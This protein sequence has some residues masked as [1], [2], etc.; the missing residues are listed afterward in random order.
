MN[1]HENPELF[2]ESLSGLASDSGILPLFIE[3]DYWLTRTLK[4]LSNYTYA[5]LFVFK[6]GTSLSKA[7]R[8]IERFSEDVDLAILADGLT[9]NQVKSRIGTTAKAITKGL[10]EV[11]QDA[12]TSKGSRFRRTAH[13]FPSVLYS[14]SHT[15][16]T[17][18]LLIEINAFGNPHPFQ[19]ETLQSMIG[20]YLKEQGRVD[21]VQQYELEPFS[22]Q[23]LSP[24][25]TFGEKV[26]AVI[27]ASYHKTPIK[28][29]QLKVRHFYDLHQMMKSPQLQGFIESDELFQ[30]LRAV[31]AD[32]ARNHEFQGEWADKPL[33]Q[34]L[35][36]QDEELWTKI[37]STY[38]HSFAQLV[39]GNLPSLSEVKTSI[40][41]LGHRLADFDR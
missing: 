9:G 5:H 32:D 10:E 29:L 39:Y 35:I 36:F 28:Q 40:N 17:P 18:Y 2:E 41:T 4:H 34:S 15:Q 37:E 6:G 20:T 31:Q 23:V 33:T 24:K 38:N 11:Y 13:T 21:L 26:L 12:V 7:Y 16:V 25:R 19:T 27:R 1:L 8:M 30:I 14:M 3:K 22:L